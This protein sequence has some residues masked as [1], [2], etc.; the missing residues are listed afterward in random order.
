MSEQHLGP[1]GERRLREAGFVPEPSPT[2]KQRWK[3]PETGRMKPGG[4]ALDEVERREER[5]LE[6]AVW[7]RE[8][9]EGE[10]CWR[11]PDSGHL[12]PRGAAYDA[13]KREGA[14]G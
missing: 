5:E 12:C 1:E 3:D 10:V 2:G 9:V 6:E 13:H 11:K 8:E 4:S 14:A 7:S